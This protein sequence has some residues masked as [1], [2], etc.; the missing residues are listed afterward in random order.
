MFCKYCGKELAEG[1]VCSCQQGQSVTQPQMDNVSDK[2][3]VT[4]QEA[5][6]TQTMGNQ[7]QMNQGM[8]VNQSQMNQGM[9]MNQGQMNQG[10]AMNQ[11]QMNQ[12]MPI[13]QN[14]VDVQKFLNAFKESFV[15][16][17]KNPVEAYEKAY[18]STDL[19]GSGLVG[20]VYLLAILLTSWIMF[21]DV[22]SA[23]SVAF[24]ITLC[25]AAIKVAFAGLCF[26]FS[27]KYNSNFKQIMSVTCISSIPH[28]VVYVVFFLCVLLKLPQATFI[29]M[30]M[31]LI[32]DIISGSA[33]TGLVFKADPK[34]KDFFYTLIC[35][36]ILVVSYLIAKK[37]VMDALKDSLSMFSTLSSLGSLY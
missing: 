29:C 19:L 13:K 21:K 20:V 12:G 4:N 28:G 31:L 24:K 25:F 10:M 23:F 35:L 36:I 32:V 9:G 6:A 5:A 26:V 8:A 22:K 30:I 34:K 11:G 37:F 33:V 7:G 14:N 27:R 17:F 3:N 18:N 2:Q 15:G 1:E 16:F